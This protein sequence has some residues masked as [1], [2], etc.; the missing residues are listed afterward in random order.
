MLQ[1]KYFEIVNEF[2]RG[3]FLEIY[4]SE[5]VGRVRLSQKAI[6]SILIELEKMGILTSKLSGNRRYYS[7]N[8][9]NPLIIDYIVLFENFAKLCFLEK[10]K[11]LIDFSKEISAKIVCIFG[12]Y[13]NGKNVSGSDLDLLV[14]GKVDNLEIKKI[15]GK[16]GFDVQIFNFS[17]ADFKKG[18]GNLVLKE[19]LK[20]HILLKGENLFVEEVIKWK[21]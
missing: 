2:L 20:N 6:S 8:F 3:Y 21:K 11:K 12:S 14:V 16:Y 1:N 5:L 18:S 9:A 15:G 19:C 10:N 4:G 7:L 13:A 17:L